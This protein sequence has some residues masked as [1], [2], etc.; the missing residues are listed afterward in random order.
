MLNLFK[1]NNH[2]HHNDRVTAGDMLWLN[3][4]KPKD[5]AVIND[6]EPAVELTDDKTFDWGTPPSKTG[7]VSIKKEEPSIEKANSSVATTTETHIVQAGETLY[8]ISKQHQLS[9]NDLKMIN[10]INS[11]GD[12]KRGQVLKVSVNEQVEETSP[13]STDVQGNEVFYEVKLSDTL[14]SVAR[15]YGVTIKDLMECNNKK[16]FS[17]SLGERLKIPSK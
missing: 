8:S 4:S 10:D 9:V 17:V 13:V 7:E 12:L 15:Q 6:D 1:K 16:D 2:L 11:E 3:S 14:Y 5:G